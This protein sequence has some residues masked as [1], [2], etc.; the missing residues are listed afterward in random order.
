MS[1]SRLNYDTGAYQHSIKE[2]VGPGQYMLETPR[3]DCGACF[4]PSPHVR[5]NTFGDSVCERQ[6]MDVDSELS[7]ITRKLTRCPTKQY[8]PNEKDYCVAKAPRECN[9]IDSEDTRLS[10]PPCTLRSTGWNRWEWLCQNPQDK[11]L[12]PFEFN[13]NNSL[14]VKDNHRPC[15]PRPIDPSSSLPTPSALMPDCPSGNWPVPAAQYPPNKTL[16]S[17][18]WRSCDEISKY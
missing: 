17:I 3:S 13:I 18:H 10:N 11:A 14:V 1:F 4:V 16:P 5:V 9:D 12:V 7:G 8:L 6:L 15:I 2:S